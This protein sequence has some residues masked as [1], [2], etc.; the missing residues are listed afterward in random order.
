MTLGSW[1]IKKEVLE[2]LHSAHQGVKAMYS[3]A[4]DISRQASLRTWKNSEHDAENATSNSPPNL[5]SP[6]PMA[7]PGCSGLLPDQG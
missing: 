7:N 3:R 6:R 1:Y 2:G 5:H 4:K